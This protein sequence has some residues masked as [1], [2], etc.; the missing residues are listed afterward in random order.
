MTWLDNIQI[1]ALSIALVAIGTALIYSVV[2]VLPWPSKRAPTPCCPIALTV[3]ELQAGV[4]RSLRA[5]AASQ[6]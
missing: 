2:Q 5:L 3:A 1:L 6:T 4:A